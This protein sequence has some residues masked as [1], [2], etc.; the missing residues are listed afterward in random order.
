L[1]VSAVQSHLVMGGGRSLY[2]GR[3]HA[4]PR[5]RFAANAILVGLD[6]AF[7]LACD[8]QRERHAAAFVPGWQWHALDFHGGRTAVLFLEPGARPHRRVDVRALRRTVEEAL[9]AREPALWAHLFQTALD[10]DVRP[11]PVDARVARAA[12]FLSAP[13]ASPANAGALAQR[14][15]VSTSHI[16]HR[17]RAE[18]GVPMGAYRAWYRMQAATAL[19]LLGKNLTELAHAGGFYDSAHFSRLFHRMFGM[20][21]SKVFTPGLTGAVVEAPWTTS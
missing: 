12:R 15:G 7:E 19:A 5:H 20:P 21:P 4:L 8:G 11:Q 2:V 18:V 16:E 14:L 13:T 17:F 10:L 9:R 1:Y 6:D 3:L